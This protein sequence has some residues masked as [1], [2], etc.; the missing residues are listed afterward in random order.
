MNN[1][2]INTEI[3]KQLALITAGQADRAEAALL[4]MI[5]IPSYQGEAAPGA[6]FGAEPAR[7]LAK[8]ADLAE[9]LGLTVTRTDHY[10]TADLGDGTSPDTVGVLCHA[11]VV[12]FGDGWHFSPTGEMTAERIYGRGALDDKGPLVASL[13]ALAAIK[14]LKLPLTRPVRII[15]GANEESGS[16][17][18]QKYVAEASIPAFGFSPDANFPVIYAEK[19]IA[20]MQAAADI[21]PGKLIRLNAGTVVN[22]VPGKAEAVLRGVPADAVNEIISGCSAKIT[23]E[24]LPTGDTK[25]TVIGKAAHGSQPEKGA[26]AAALLLAILAALPLDEA[27]SRLIRNISQL[28][29][30]D[31]HGIAAGIAATDDIS[32]KLTLNLG[33]VDWADGRCTLALDMRYPVT[34]AF[35]D[36]YQQLAA[37]TADN[38]LVLSI[39]EHKAPLYVPRDSE[40]VTTLLQLY[41]EYQPDA[42]ALAIGGGTY[43]RSFANFVAFG[44]LRHNTADLMHQADEYITR[45]DFG[46]LRQIY[47]QA[48]WRLAGK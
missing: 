12:P 30:S 27:E 40:P 32:G 16:R 25:L 37:I 34:A 11:D 20:L 8:A 21:T 17:C 36:I 15:I 28:F 48:I 3:E 26:N 23:A 42:E 19:G 14:E 9:A 29:G 45:E 22:A 47:A 18:M 35:E 39:D 5:A 24:A 1:D 4:E 46:F 44:P 38:G 2:S 33:K 13:F 41:R 6:P 7:A 10:I 43:C 31:Y